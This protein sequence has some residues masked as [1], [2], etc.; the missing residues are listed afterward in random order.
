MGAGIG[1]ILRL[2][3]PARC[4]RMS[5]SSPTSRPSSRCSARSPTASA[6]CSKA[7]STSSAPRSRPS[8][9]SSPR[10][11][12]RRALRR[13]R[14]R[15]R[16]H[17]D[18]AARP[19]RRARRRG[20]RPGRH[21]L[22]DPRGRRQRRR[23][24]GLLRHRPRHLADD[25]RDGG[26]AD[27]RSKT[28][29][30]L[31]VHLFGNPAPVAELVALGEAA[32]IKVLEDAAQAH[33][34]TLGGAKAGRRSATRRP[35]ASSPPRTSARSATRG[36]VV[37]TDPEVE[38]LARRLRF[39]GSEDKRTHTEI[40]YNSRLDELQAAGLR[41]LLPHLA[42]WTAA[43][44]AAAA[45]LRGRRARRPR[46]APGRDRWRR[47]LLPPLR[48]LAPR[49][50]RAARAAH[51]GRHRRAALLRDPA[52]QPARDGAATRPPSRCENTER[53]CAE[54]LALPMGT[55]LDPDAP[56][57]VTEA[58]GAALGARA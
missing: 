38:A 10:S 56:A 33:G 15:H 48:G 34:A 5:P 41:V 4:P 26:A 35:S 54:I 16:R 13:R 21:L 36:A 57:Q 1:S 49:A 29:A 58:V 22:R 3:C 19:R 45:G 2:P 24:A 9:R 40:G 31:P 43:R 47:V 39:H 11:C 37:T 8:S 18:R 50:R 7:G 52:L 30:F 6:P 17:P 44:R 14:Q 27:H 23:D 20:G 28:K 53:V 42:D 51:R 46:R 55:A 12:R 25:R 32:G